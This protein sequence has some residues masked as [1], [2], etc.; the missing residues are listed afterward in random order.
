MRP[1]RFDLNPRVN[2]T[3]GRGEP[4]KP[5]EAAARTGCIPASGEVAKEATKVTGVPAA[6]QFL[7]EA[8]ERS[9]A[10][11]LGSP[12]NRG[13]AKVAA[14]NAKNIAHRSGAQAKS[15][16]RKATD[17][18][19]VEALTEHGMGEDEARQLVEQEMRPY[20]AERGPHGGWSSKLH[21]QLTREIPE[22][23]RAATAL[24]RDER[25]ARSRIDARAAQVGER[26]DAWLAA[27]PWKRR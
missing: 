1:I 16:L 3:Y 20:L 5:G 24:F 8:L 21:E 27:K 15:R 13:E 26:V 25:D 23:Y 6:D 19:V 4:C 11:A 14:D 22:G 10:E 7:G 2:L 17:A 18:K 9:V 12:R